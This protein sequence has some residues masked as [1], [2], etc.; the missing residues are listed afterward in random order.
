MSRDRVAF[1]LEKAYTAPTEQIRAHWLSVAEAWRR[2]EADRRAAADETK[3]AASKAK[4]KIIK[5]SD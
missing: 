3:R 4:L 1:Y 2:Q 5:G